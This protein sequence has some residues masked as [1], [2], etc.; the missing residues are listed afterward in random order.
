METTSDMSLRPQIIG[1]CPR[2]VAEGACE[3]RILHFN[4]GGSPAL[5]AQIVTLFS[6]ANI[7]NLC[8]SRALVAV[9]PLLS[10]HQ[11]WM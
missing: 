6:R 8:S 3:T 2:L 10:L 7:N 1:L 4:L 5:Q 11:G 9:L